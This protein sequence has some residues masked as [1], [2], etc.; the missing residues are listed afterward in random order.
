MIGIRMRVTGYDAGQI[1]AVIERNAPAM[2]KETLTAGEY[3]AK[4]RNRNWK[5][6]AGE[7]TAK[8]VFGPRGAAQY[9]GAEPYRPLY[10]RIE[11][12]GSFTARRQPVPEREAKERGMERK[13]EREMER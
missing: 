11:G 13:Q 9:A 12:R 3:D 7:T 4:Y 2:R 5:R 10:M 8:F 1:R 6:Y